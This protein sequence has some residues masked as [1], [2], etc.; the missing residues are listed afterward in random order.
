MDFK[1]TVKAEKRRL[2]RVVKKSG[3]DSDKQKAV[4]ENL[5][6]MK[7]KLDET[8]AYLENE[9]LFCEYDNGGGQSGVREHPGYK[10]YESLW[11]AYLSGLSQLTP[12][13]KKAE[14]AADKP[15]NV[16]SL[17]MANRRQKVT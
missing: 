12:A 1:G 11:R 3:G 2:A 17:V 9:K 16:L 14:P 7:A 4:I 10:A 5:A 8:R 13:A 15:E 6:F